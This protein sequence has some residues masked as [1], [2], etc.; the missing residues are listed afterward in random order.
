MNL[1]HIEPT[2]TITDQNPTIE[3]F[4]WPALNTEWEKV[5]VRPIRNKTAIQ[6]RGKKIYGAVGYYALSEDKCS[7]IFHHI[8]YSSLII[9]ISTRERMI[10]AMNP[11]M[12]CIWVCRASQHE[13]ICKQK[14]KQSE[15]DEYKYNNEWALQAPISYVHNFHFIQIWCKR[16]Q[17]FRQQFNLVEF[18]KWLS[19]AYP[20]VRCWLLFSQMLTLSTLRRWDILKCRKEQLQQQ[21]E[22]CNVRKRRFIGNTK[23]CENDSSSASK[24]SGTTTVPL[25]RVHTW[26]ICV[27]E[28]STATDAINS[29]WAFRYSFIKCQQRNTQRQ[30]R[31]FYI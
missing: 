5:V 15:E 4:C 30:E 3:L 18:A 12:Y 28:N 14:Q 7:R 17:I 25:S 13:E 11:I 20:F 22:Q 10:N 1:A 9:C 23:M 6:W 29:R 2:I 19:S 8:C 27:I 26:K 31:I 24:T 21:V 16:A